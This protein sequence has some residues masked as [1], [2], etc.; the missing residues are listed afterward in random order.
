MIC[1]LVCS[2]VTPCFAPCA[3][4]P[5]CHILRLP[6]ALRSCACCCTKNKRIHQVHNTGKFTVCACLR[7][8]HTSSQVRKTW[9]QVH[10]EAGNCVSA[11]KAVTHQVYL[12][13]PQVLLRWLLVMPRS[14][15]HVFLTLHMA[16][17][18]RSSPMPV[19]CPLN[20]VFCCGLC[21]L[22]L[23]RGGS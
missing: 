6:A 19:L 18:Q 17:I 7:R 20:T 5:V 16:W 2:L 23:S 11:G 22:I 15:G 9:N 21:S 1:V 3:W 12:V 13:L 8:Q 14:T 10:Q 4:L